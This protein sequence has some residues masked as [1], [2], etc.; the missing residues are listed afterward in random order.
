MVYE[1]NTDKRQNKHKKEE[2]TSPVKTRL[3]VI[4]MIIFRYL[5]KDR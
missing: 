4:T 1:L 3:R 5:L 2:V